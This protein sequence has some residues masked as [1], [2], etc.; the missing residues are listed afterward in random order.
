MAP[1]D[2][3]DDDD[4]VL[5]RFLPPV[6]K[7]FR[8]TL[9]TPTPPQRLGWPAI[10]AGQNT[11]IWRRRAGK[12]LAAFS[13]HST[14]SGGHPERRACGSSTLAAESPE[15][16]RPAQPRRPRS[17]E[18][19]N[20]TRLGTPLSPLQVAVR[21]GDTSTRDRARIVTSPRHPDHDA[22]VA[23]LMLTSPGRERG[24]GVS[25]VIVDEIHS[26]CGDERGFR[27]SARA[28]PGQNTGRSSGRTVGD[29]AAARRG[30]P[31][32]GR[33]GWR[34]SRGTAVR[35]AGRSRSSTP[36][37][38]RRWTCKSSGPGPTGANS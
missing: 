36:A 30:G 34:D 8:E 35:A 20:I 1:L 15:R 11:L 37:G 33:N 23:A 9:G 26:V 21:S 28:A 5:V 27:P 6:S 32:P 14:C 38:G 31:L 19:S 12:T 17:R 7:W 22:R 18:S 4:D 24:W 16:G 13:R 10:A 25:H 29:A 3:G 2:H